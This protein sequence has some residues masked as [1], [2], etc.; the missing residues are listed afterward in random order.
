MFS[1]RH[2]RECGERNI[3]TRIACAFL[4]NRA[5]NGLTPLA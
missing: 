1:K 3:F 5:N 2:Q 4:A